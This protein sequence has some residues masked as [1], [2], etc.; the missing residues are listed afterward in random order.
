M[1]RVLVSVEI[2]GC[3]D[4]K[5]HGMWNVELS[6]VSGV[7]ASTAG[8]EGKSESLAQGRCGSVV[9]LEYLS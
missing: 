4:E 7:A 8:S 1:L 2:T 5:D 9:S 3:D 6:W